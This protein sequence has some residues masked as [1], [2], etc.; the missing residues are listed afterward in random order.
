MGWWVE[1]S[2]CIFKQNPCLKNM[3]HDC[4]VVSS[5]ER[6]HLHFRNKVVKWPHS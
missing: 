5:V 3:F 6:A 2:K 4:S 1:G